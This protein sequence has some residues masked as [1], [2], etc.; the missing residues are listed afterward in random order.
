MASA[1]RAYAQ[2][3]TQKLL[4]IKVKVEEEKKKEKNMI[5]PDICQNSKILRR[6]ST[7]DLSRYFK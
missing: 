7:S 2:L 4:L 5:L 1:A 3:K 6:I